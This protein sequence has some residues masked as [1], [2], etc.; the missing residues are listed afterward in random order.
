MEQ[1]RE[2]VTA[3]LEQAQQVK[4]QAR[5][6][7]RSRVEQTQQIM[8]QGREEMMAHLERERAESRRQAL[9]SNTGK[10]FEEVHI[11]I[12]IYTVCVEEEYH[13]MHPCTQHRCTCTYTFP[14]G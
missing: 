4:E 5:E 3:H 7:M 8:E 6:K 10:M 14:G 1:E 12:H 11:Y 2:A 9:P 13:N